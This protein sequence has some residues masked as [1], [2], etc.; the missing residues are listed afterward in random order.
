MQ[1]KYG[2][3]ALMFACKKFNFKA[4]QL[5]YEYEKDIV[6]D[7]RVT[8]LMAVCGNTPQTEEEMINQINIINLL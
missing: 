4:V 7:E 2:S 6:S 5:L 3:T 8:A 1:D